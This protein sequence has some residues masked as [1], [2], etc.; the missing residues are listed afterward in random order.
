[1]RLAWTLIVLFIACQCRAWFFLAWHIYYFEQIV[2]HGGEPDFP[3]QELFG[4]F[5]MQVL[6]G[7][8]LSGAFSRLSIAALVV[9]LPQKR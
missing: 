5:H 3:A 2:F 4:I 8:I 1:M 7:A 6:E 9:I